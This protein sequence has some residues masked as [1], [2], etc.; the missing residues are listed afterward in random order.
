MNKPANALNLKTPS[1]K[2]TL[3]FLTN[4]R[5]GALLIL[6]VMFIILGTVNRTFFSPAT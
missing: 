4:E 2:A 3:K 5:I 6:V 1:S